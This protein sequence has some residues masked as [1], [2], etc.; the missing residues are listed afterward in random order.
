MK[1][2]DTNHFVI[3]GW[4]TAK[5]RL[6]LSGLKLNVYAIVFGFS[7]DGRNNCDAS[8][9][10][11]A[12]FAGGSIRSVKNCLSDL[13]EAGILTKIER[14]ASTGKSNAYQANMEILDFSK[15]NWGF[16]ELEPS[17]G[18]ECKNCT[19]G[20]QKLHGGECKNCTPY[21]Y[22]NLDKKERKNINNI[23]TNSACAY[24]RDEKSLK[25]MTE[26]ELLDYANEVS[27]MGSTGTTDIKEIFRYNKA[28]EDL[29]EEL[30]RR[31]TENS[32]RGKFVLKEGKLEP[33][34]SWSQ[35]IEDFGLSERVK[36]VIMEFIKYRNAS[37]KF[38]TNS[39]LEDLCFRL[40]DLPDDSAR[41]DSITLA[42][43][44]GFFDIKEKS[45]WDVS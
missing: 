10:Y 42:M 21:I 7:Q 6:A 39:V 25:D 37:G 43:R 29:Q 33:M 15:E 17:E 12:E 9:E 13:T 23:I 45:M 2:K 18:G 34:K 41:V 5:N 40:S 1:V 3:H 22:L 14:N 27:K 35:I 8:I 44:K 24:A 31:A 28:Y 16:S 19:P 11:I 20:V 32:F 30:R 26:A 4:M 38:V 36:N